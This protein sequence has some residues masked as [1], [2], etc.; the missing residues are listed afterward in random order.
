MFPDPSIWISS[1][2]QS[3]LIQEADPI[4]KVLCEETQD[5]DNV[6]NNSHVSWN[7]TQVHMVQLESWETITLAFY[8]TNNLTL[9]Y[10]LKTSL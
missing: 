1:K 7:W 3:H 6:Q 2:A 9:N 10:N 8:Y 5:M 4:Y